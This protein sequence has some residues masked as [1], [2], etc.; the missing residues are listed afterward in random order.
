MP[1]DNTHM[2]KRTITKQVLV[3][4]PDYRNHR[5]GIGA[6]I[7]IHKDYYE[8]FNFIPTYRPY[9][10]NLLKSLFF[11]RQYAYIV[12]QLLKSGRHIRIVHI[13][14]SKHGSF[15]RKLLIGTTAKLLFGKRI[16][17]HI[18][19]GNFKRFYDN[20]NV[21][22]KKIIASFLKLNDVTITVSDSW[23]FYFESIFNLRNV[24]KINNIVVSPSSSN[25]TKAPFTGNKCVHFLF[26]G[27]IDHNKGIFD[28]LQVLQQHKQTLAGKCKLLIGGSGKV[29]LLNNTIREAGLNDLVEF[30]GWV[31]GDEKAQLL[32]QADVFIL[33]SYFEGVPVAILEAM[34]YGKPIIATAVGGIPEI[35]KNGVNGIL[36][37]PGDHAALLAAMQLY[38]SNPENIRQQGL[39]SLEFIKDYYPDIIMPR[40]EGLYTSLL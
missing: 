19:T 12:Y 8:E 1:A 28:L 40:L 14:A 21:I 24:Y 10:N 17:Y 31:S 35:V 34:S 6:V 15:Y 25:T 27:L 16:I 36:C 37:S 39:C 29:G 23:K 18:H 4:G 30:K 20:S 13:H 33:P 32:Q 7:G 5:G 9:R 22:S 26:L 2:I 3:V 38:I 11:I